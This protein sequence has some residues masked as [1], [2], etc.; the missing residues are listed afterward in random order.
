MATV[1]VQK[2]TFHETSRV[3]TEGSGR[4]VTLRKWFHTLRREKFED[5]FQEDECISV[6]EAESLVLVPSFNLNS[7]YTSPEVPKCSP[8][9]VVYSHRHRQKIRD[10]KIQLKLK[11][12]HL[13]HR[14]DKTGHRSSEVDATKGPIVDTRERV[15]CVKDLF[16]QCEEQNDAVG[17]GKT[18]E[19]KDQEVL[20]D[21]QE[22]TDNLDETDEA[23]VAVLSEQE[24]SLSASGSYRMKRHS[25]NEPSENSSFKRS[26][27]TKDLTSVSSIESL[28]GDNNDGDSEQGSIQNT[29]PDY[30]TKSPVS[31]DASSTQEKQESPEALNGTKLFAESDDEGSLNMRSA[32]VNLSSDCSSLSGDMSTT[33][34]DTVSEAFSCA[35]STTGEKVYTIPTFRRRKDSLNV[36]NIVKSFKDGTLN[37]EQL[38]QFADKGANGAEDLTFKNREFYDDPTGAVQSTSPQDEAKNNNKDTSQKGTSLD[39]KSTLRSKSKKQEGAVKFDRFSCLIVYK[40]STKSSSLVSDGVISLRDCNRPQG[41]IRRQPSQTRAL[42]QDPEGC[43]AKSILKIKANSREKEEIRRAI[44]CDEVDIESFMSLFEHFESKRQMEELKLGEVRE[45]QLNHYYSDKFFP[46]IVEDVTQATANNSEFSRSRKATEL[47]IG[48][49]LGAIKC[50]FVHYICPTCDSRIK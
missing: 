32:R 16:Q 2:D 20:R 19:M 26:C 31:P 45:N 28:R 49:N 44:R 30:L 9:R 7:A 50:G 42:K 21:R 11:L 24:G 38:I 18:T 4:R 37:E 46:E 5:Q 41:S 14:H 22:P 23:C 34:E 39:I 35:A 8:E 48:R 36:A 10:F 13:K 33:I 1:V 6:E 47:N 3:N 27:S 25:N 12:H 43:E 29:P 40:P 17:G 15:A